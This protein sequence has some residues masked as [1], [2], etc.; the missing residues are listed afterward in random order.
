[1]NINKTRSCRTEGRSLARLLWSSVALALLLSVL[2]APAQPASEQPRPVVAVFHLRGPLTELPADNLLEMFG[3][4]V[5]SLK[6]LTA[7][8][9]KA[10]ADPLVKAVVLLPE[11]SWVGA[12]QAEELRASL[13]RVRQRGKDV[14]VHAD[15]LLMGQYLL[16]CGASRVSVVPNGGVFV[17]GLHASSL[18]LRGL[19]DKIGVKPDFITEGAY[20][21]AAELFMRDQPS[22]E[23]DEM[24]NWLMDSWYATFRDAIAQGRKAD[25]AKAQGWLDAGLFTAE[26]AKAAGLIDAVEHQPDFEALLTNRFGSEVVFDKRYGSRKQPDIDFS[27]P[28]GLVSFWAQLVT[29]PEKKSTGRPAVGIVY[30]TGG[31]VTGRRTTAPF[32]AGNVGAFSSDLRDTLEKAAADDSIAAVVLRIDSPGGSASEIILDAARR[33]KAR[34][35]VV[36]SMGAVA[37]S[38]GY[39]AACGADTI[40]ADAATLTGSIGVLGGKF[41]TTEMWK[42]IGVTFKEYKRGQNAG[43]LSTDDVFTESERARV[44]A[45]LDEC[46]ATFKRRVTEARASRLKKPIEE[47]AG[48]RVY[49]GRQ[50]LDLGLVDRL[51]T[52]DD[53]VAFAA[54]QAKVKD[55]DVRVVPEPQNFLEQLMDQISGGRDEPGHV[56]LAAGEPSLWRLAAPYLQNLDPNRTAAIFSALA[57]LEIVQKEGMALSMPGI[58][59]DP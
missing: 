23:A 18:H 20:K 6:E 26:Q 4:H 30:I 32:G 38:G 47:V 2:R 11:S 28:L 45:A 21:S 49:T 57:R 10:A 15:S 9:D 35:P 24:I 51:G 5:I 50:A 44:R 42:K 39:Y 14:Y 1:M 19:L 13:E 46:Y 53:A 33:V 29:P 48:G 58:V 52:L 41:A 3:P 22:L 59:L 55:Y 12:A 16:A 34:K 43:M 17:P 31:M 54:E 25:V 8:L 37:A 27:N 36:V 7:R 40:F 56:E